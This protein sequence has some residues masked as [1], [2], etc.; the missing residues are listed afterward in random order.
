[1]PPGNRGAR[2]DVWAC[3]RVAVVQRELAGVPV[4]ACGPHDALIP[5][6]G[7]GWRLHGTVRGDLVLWHPEHAPYDPDLSDAYR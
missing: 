1:M 6:A 5:H 4:L 2:C 7:V 3:K